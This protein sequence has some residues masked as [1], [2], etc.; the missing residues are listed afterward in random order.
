MRRTTLAG[1]LAGLTVLVVVTLTAAVAAASAPTHAPVSPERPGGV[2]VED[3][4]ALG[5]SYT[6]GPFIPQTVAALGC[7]RST[8]NYPA[9]LAAELD[10]ETLS[11]VSCSG[12]DTRHLTSPQPTGFASVPPQL[13]ALSADTDLVT[14]GIGGNDFGVFGRLVTT[15]PRLRSQDPDG[16][17]CRDHFG[18]EGRDALMSD[19]ATTRDRLDEAVEEIRRRAPHAQ[20]L[21]VGYPRIAPMQGTCP[22]VLPF[23]DGDYRYAN[24]V[25]RRLNA[26][27]R[28]A[29]RSHDVAYVDTYAASRGHDACAGDQAWVNGQHT[30]TR[31]AQSYHPFGSYMRAVADLVLAELDR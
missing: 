13:A 24:Q 2:E 14:V 26:A 11:D 4:V 25:E 21:L 5:D 10:V 23:A 7:F 30:D 18:G 29:A 15:C 17:P 6:A 1:R 3:Y 28:H 12:A 9:L 20:V 22:A 31:R 19:L 8:H 16:D 27:L